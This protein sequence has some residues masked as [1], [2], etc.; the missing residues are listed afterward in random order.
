MIIGGYDGSYES[1]HKVEIID[2]SSE[3]RSCPAIPDIPGAEY[4]HVATFINDRALACGGYSTATSLYY[5]DCYSYV[6]NVSDF[7]EPSLVNNF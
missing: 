7:F 4:G 3:N 2:L 5:S 1:F 6:N